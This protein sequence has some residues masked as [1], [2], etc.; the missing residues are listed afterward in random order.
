MNRG[1][2]LQNVRVKGDATAALVSTSTPT[3]S[4]GGSRGQGRGQAQDLAAQLRHPLP[5]PAGPH[6]EEPAQRRRQPL[7]GAHDLL[8]LGQEQRHH[9]LD[10]FQA[11]APARAAS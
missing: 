1:G 11:V 9:P 5:V 8:G 10:G 3:Q 6:V 7:V 2:S 4:R